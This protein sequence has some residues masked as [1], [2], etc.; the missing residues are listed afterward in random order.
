MR[1]VV[2]FALVIAIVVAGCGGGSDKTS[3]QVESKADFIALGDVICKNHQSRRED[4]ESQTIDL[5]PLDSNDKAHQ[6]AAL[7]RQQRSNL[8]AEVQELQARQPPPADVGRVESILTI[9]RAKA[10]LIGKWAKA[11]D[12]LN[13]DEIRTRQV[14]IGLATTKAR[15]AAQTYG[16]EVCGQD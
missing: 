2:S 7:L 16:F 4:L 3:T 1:G 5:G 6:V 10:D 14:R 11:Y 9:I 12:D 15:K 8:Q 13:V